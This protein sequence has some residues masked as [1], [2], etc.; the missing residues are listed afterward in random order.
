MS[1][2]LYM[3][4][5]LQDF[6][7]ALRQLRKSPGFFLVAAL[8][9]AIAIGVNSAIFTVVNAFLVKKP[10]VP[11]PDRLLV[12]SSVNLAERAGDRSA[13]SA[14][15]Y[16][17]WRAQATSL[18][19]MTAAKF[20]DFTISSEQHPQRVAG[21]RVCSE[22][23]QMMGVAPVLGRSIAPRESDPVAV[24]SDALWRTR[25]AAARTV[26]GRTLKVDGVT[27]T[28]VGVMP[29]S[30]RNWEFI[31]DIWVPLN[32]S[33][34]DL[35]PA[36]RN[37]RSLIVFARLKPEI[38]LAQVNEEMTAIARRIAVAHPETNKNWGTRVLTLQEYSLADAD[39]RTSLS[40]LMS[41]VGFVLLIACA[42]VACL[43]LSRNAS[44]TQEFLTRTVLG[45]GRMRLTRQLLAE[46]LCLSFAA[47]ALGIFVG[48]LGIAVI[49]RQLNWGTE[50]LEWAKEIVIDPNVLLFTLGI[51]T[52]A[53]ILFGLFPALQMARRHPAGSLGEASRWATGGR[54]QHRLQKVLVVSQLA[55]SLV[56]SVGAG[57]FVE[58]FIEEMRAKTG[59]NE[60][61]ILTASVAL[62]GPGYG[63]AQKQSAFF[64]NVSDQLRRESQIESVALTDALPFSFPAQADFTIEAS[65]GKAEQHAKSGL[66]LIS[67]GYFSAL[68]LAIFEGRE[69][70]SSDNAQ[71]TP[72]VVVDRSFAERYFG[73]TDPIAHHI[74]IDRDKTNNQW[75]EIVGVVRDVNEFLGQQAPR[76]HIYEPFLAYPESEMSILIRTRTSPENLAGALRGAVAAI[77]R[78]QAVSNLRTMRRVISD[79]GAGDDLMSGLMTTFALVA[80]IMAAIGTYGV[81]SHVV[82]Q[83]T[84][85]MGIRVAVGA[86]P[87]QV[88]RMVIRS[89]ATLSGIGVLLGVSASLAMPKLMAA[90]FSGFRFHSAL[91]IVAAPITVLIIAL[92]AGYIPARRAAKTDPMVALRYE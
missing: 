68:Q 92:V 27:H 83:R 17:D 10:R 65:S 53:A 84:K 15:D 42:N 52:A 2:E 11:D 6:R 48:K 29:A 69:F 49:R 30:F 16:L 7:F 43:L 37:S 9:L 63:S 47:G 46:C 66:V 90:L 21:A 91:V 64:V 8:T 71:A 58:G 56:L 35:S 33:A 59:F 41:T 26:L 40:F 81:L 34:P 62:R 60:N 89:G 14:L 61:N 85:E 82:S 1:K 72:V 75:S 3:T 70:A 13:V 38:G 87:S 39:V 57:L 12:I 23:F 76:P 45:A 67:P 31:A 78:D 51:A 24:I 44:R 50:T 74:R 28:I 77:D 4:G 18:N 80:L 79:S 55:L 54:N 32:F 22:F 5:L 19:G 86:N 36:S 25:F 20:D 88:R 73:K